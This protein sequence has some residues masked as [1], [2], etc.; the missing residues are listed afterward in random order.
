MF[1]IKKIA[2][3]SICL[4]GDWGKGFRLHKTKCAARKKSGA[5]VPARV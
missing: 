4:K 3:P 5:I 1:I 2:A